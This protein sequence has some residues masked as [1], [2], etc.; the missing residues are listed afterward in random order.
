LHIKP[1]PEQ[2]QHIAGLVVCISCIDFEWRLNFQYF[3]F[4]F[5][6]QVTVEVSHLFLNISRNSAVTHSM[7]CLMPV[8]SE[9]QRLQ[10]GTLVEMGLVTLQ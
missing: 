7:V 6:L 4:S 2:I 9:P 1:H 10:S 8:S 5:F 3:S